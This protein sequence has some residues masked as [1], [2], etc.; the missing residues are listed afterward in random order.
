MIRS[1]HYA[2]Y[3]A[4]FG[5]ASVVRRDDVGALEPW[6]QFWYIWSSVAFLKGYLQ[7]ADKAPFLPTDK[8][9][10][11]LLVDAFMIDKA[12]YEIGYELDNRPNWLT[13]P[14]RGILQLLQDTSTVNP[15]S[16]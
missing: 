4:L 15:P 7:L 13:V 14:L 1:F 5:E 10:L 8:T 16:S 2:A 9:Q 12:I 3:N 11:Q 6:A